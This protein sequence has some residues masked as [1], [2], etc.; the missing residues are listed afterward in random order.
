M[1]KEDNENFENSTK[2]WVCVNDYVDNGVKLKD[3]SHITG[4]YIGGTHK[5]RVRVQ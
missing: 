3:H 2:C 1:T 5:D 4:K